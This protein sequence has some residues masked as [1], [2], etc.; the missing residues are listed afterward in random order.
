MKCAKCGYELPA[1]SEFCQYCGAKIVIAYPNPEPNLRPES[2]KAHSKPRQTFPVVLSIVL[3]IVLVIVVAAGL[4][5]AWMLSKADDESASPTEDVPLSAEDIYTKI[6]PSVVEIVA[7]SSTEISTGTGFFYDNKGTVITNYH[8]IENCQKAEIIIGNGSKFEVTSVL[9]YDADRD[10]AILSTNCKFSKPLSIRSTTVKTGEK[11]YAIG[12]SLGLTG[13]LSDGIISAVNRIV[14]GNV[15]IQTTA[16]ISKGNSGGPLVDADGKVVGIICASFTDGQ[17][18]NLAIPIDASKRI[19]TNNPITLE[20][21]FPE[22]VQEVEWISDWRFLYYADEDTYVLLFQLADKDEIPMSASGTAKIRIVNNDNVTVYNKTHDF[23]AENFE[24]WI[25]N[26][27]DEMYLA[28][29]YISPQSIINGST[30]YG[31]VYFEVS[32][33]GYRF[34]ECTATAV[35]LPTGTNSTSINPPQGG[36]TPPTTQP[37]QNNPPTN[38]STKYTCL[39]PSC[40]NKVDNYGEYCSEHR[41]A[42]SD[43]PYSKD[44]DSNYCS[45]CACF[46]AGCKNC[47]IENGY[48]CTNHTCVA[49]GCTSEKTS[50]SD[51]CYYHQNYSNQDSTTQPPATTPP[52]TTPPTTPPTQYTCIDSTCD[53]AV[54][55]RG[56]YC[57]E[58]KCANAGCS[59][60]KEYNSN[61]CG[62]CTCNH[63]GCKNPQ[64]DNGYYCAEHTCSATGCTL[65]KSYGKLY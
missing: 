33:N 10:I 24:E 62:S 34:E 54:S 47:R 21:L 22:P 18:L 25:Y 41:C 44:S 57:S 9:G 64:N 23:T 36:T 39:D 19:S 46:T 48:Y 38:P 11:V 16:P 42:N 61:Y 7:E 63:V 3:S 56:Q 20:E 65:E 59:H 49:N 31:T 50:S 5:A 14:E 1:D 28:A 35:D 32:G 13:S 43:C 45:V 17:N 2:K 40:N 30:K 12:S 15:Y 6:S 51:Y 4:V 37:P 26:D 55:E 8:V 52:A 29:I 58:H 53:N 60:K 27:T